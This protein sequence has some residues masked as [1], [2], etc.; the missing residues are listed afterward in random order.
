MGNGTLSHLLTLSIYIYAL[1]DLCADA[2]TMHA[3]VCF[4]GVFY[5]SRSIDCI[6]YNLDVRYTICGVLYRVW[7][8][9]HIRFCSIARIWSAYMCLCVR[10]HTLK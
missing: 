8:I 7:Y 10:A 2:A 3:I 6:H 5:S 4:L 1:D 9:L